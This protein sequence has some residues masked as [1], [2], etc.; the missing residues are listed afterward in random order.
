MRK[1]L[2]DKKANALPVI[3]FVLT[4]ITCGAL[5]T[6]F[7]IEVAFPLLQG[8]IPAGDNKVF[9]MMLMYAIPLFVVFVGLVAL[10]LQGI[11][12]EVYVQQ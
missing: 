6:L 7:F 9:V 10:L 4:I 3:L 12:K 8:Y 2:H 11:K 5:Y 1:L